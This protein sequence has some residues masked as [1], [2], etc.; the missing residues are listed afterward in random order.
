MSAMQNKSEHFPNL[1]FGLGL[2]IPHYK[3]IFEHSPEVDW[4]EIISENFMDTD[5]MPKRNLARMRE[6][7]PIVMHG[8][9]MSIG[10]V[11]PLD[12]EYLR[13]LKNLIDFVQ[14]AW[15][16][17]HLCW[18][19]IAHKNSHDLLPVPYTEEALK[20]IVTRIKQVQDFLE[21]PI[22]LENPST[23][24]EFKTSNIPEAEFIAAMVKESGCHLLLDVNNVYVSC[25]NH[26]LDAKAYIDALPIDK[27]AQI[28]LSGHSNKGTHIIDTHDDY[29]VDEVW[30][31][32]RYATHKAGRTIN[33]MVEWDDKL[34]EFDVLYAELGKAKAAARDAQNY[35]PLPNLFVEQAPYVA[36]IITS[37]DEAET[38]MQEAILQGFDV[39]SKPHEWIRAKEQFAP[40]AQLEV[41]QNAY[42]WRLYDVT[43]EDYPVLKYYLG[44]QVFEDLIWNF[45]NKF[46]SSHFNIGRFSAHLPEFLAKH[47][48]GDDF[49]CEIAELESAVS[50]L[51]DP[52][53][54]IALQPSHLL[55]MTA[56][57]L[58]ESVLY[59]REALQLFAFDYPV[60]DYYCAV[61]EE[62]NPAAPALKKSFTAVFRH[63]DIVWRM[64]LAEDEY[65]LLEKLFSGM[66]IGEALEAAQNEL[67]L[68]E[69]VLSANLS[70]WFSR[71]MRNGLLAKREDTQLKR[72]VA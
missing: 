5:G 65:Q 11:D 53:E 37:L 15:I 16:S 27:V 36:N 68:S 7:Y 2:R 62:K 63:E 43:A 44:D 59:P 14:P 72:S 29:V 10:T 34:P 17:D 33:T 30:S 45:V 9:A 26:R 70:E 57:T 69:D 12:S 23:Y 24:L 25:Y 48:F 22:A 66:P 58:M 40:A 55:G 60:N 54:T 50:Q 8:I 46:P 21:R 49:A 19:G 39:D 47:P 28:H 41:Y 42:R 13:K 20:H 61:M 56:E 31:L 4:F 52:A 67:G 6:R 32:Y 3:H 38:R 1:G 18:T 35:A 51:G 64:N 71:W